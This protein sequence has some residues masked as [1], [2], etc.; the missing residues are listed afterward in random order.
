MKISKRDFHE[1]FVNPEY[2]N[3]VTTTELI[4][5]IGFGRNDFT[6]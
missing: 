5:R 2:F 4:L 1:R 3:W 6:K